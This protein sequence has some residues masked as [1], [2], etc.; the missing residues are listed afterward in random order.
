MLPVPR[1]RI[2]RDVQDDEPRLLPAAE[3]RDSSSPRARI[4]SPRLIN[5][6]VRGQGVQQL[7]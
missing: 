5:V 3:H 2:S 6:N 4:R 7:R 1:R